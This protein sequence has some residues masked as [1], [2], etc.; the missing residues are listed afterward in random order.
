MKIR[1]DIELKVLQ[2]T[3]EADAAE[4][5][6]AIAWSFIVGYLSGYL[7]ITPQEAEAMLDKPAD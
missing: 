4:M 1:D 3:G 6:G 2:H 5:A 7:H